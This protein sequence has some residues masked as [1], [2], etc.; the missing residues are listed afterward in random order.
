MPPL[1]TWRADPR[2]TPVIRAPTR[3]TCTSP[4]PA[5]VGLAARARHPRA[6]ST[7]AM[8]LAGVVGVRTPY[9]SFLAT[10]NGPDQVLHL[11]YRSRA[12]ERADT[13]L[14]LTYLGRTSSIGIAKKMNKGVRTPTT[15]G[16]D[17]GSRTSDLGPGN[18]LA[19]AWWRGPPCPL[20]GSRP[21]SSGTGVCTP[22]QSSPGTRRQAGASRGT[23]AVR[24][25]RCTSRSRTVLSD[26][27]SWD[28]ATGV[29]YKKK[30]GGPPPH[31]LA[32]RSE[33]RPWDSATGVAF[34]L[35]PEGP[36]PQ[37]GGSAT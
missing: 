7:R 21:R 6:P 20:G 13:V 22:P 12:P 37:A 15:R 35:N 1:G 26:V 17:L 28:P 24:R 16:P 29:A 10:P 18:F 2:R 14:H 32:A 8:D 19:R 5:Q 36:P 3:A 30:S 31:E 11:P 27:R 9:S 34:K 33:V 23:S 25:G 4:R